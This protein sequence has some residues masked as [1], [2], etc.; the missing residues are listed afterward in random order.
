MKAQ[1]PEKSNHDLSYF[2]ARFCR[3]RLAE[4]EWD[5][6]VRE[7]EGGTGVGTGCTSEN[8]FQNTGDIFDF[9]KSGGGTQVNLKIFCI[10]H[11]ALN[12][13][14]RFNTIFKSK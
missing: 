1:K 14:G 12:R 7:E 6:E 10:T 8:A 4:R 11:I 9:K 3:S 5:F 2:N 13:I